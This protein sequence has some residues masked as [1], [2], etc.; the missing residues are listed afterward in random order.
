VIKR[1]KERKGFALTKVNHSVPK[2]KK[3]GAMIRT[4]IQSFEGP[5]LQQLQAGGHE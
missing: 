1:L 4:M 5:F 3:K 2:T